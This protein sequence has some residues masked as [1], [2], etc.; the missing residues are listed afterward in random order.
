MAG[1][2]LKSGRKLHAEVW[3]VTSSCSLLQL[4]R[5]PARAHLHFLFLCSPFFFFRHRIVVAAS[6]NRSANNA[7]CERAVYGFSPRPFVRGRRDFRDTGL[8]I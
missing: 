8:A 1:K 5:P 7:K 6:E 3:S 4:D 2:S